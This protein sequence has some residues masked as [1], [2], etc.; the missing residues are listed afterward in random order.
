MKKIVFGTMMT[1]GAVSLQGAFD[2]K[3]PNVSRVD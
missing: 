3:Y 2:T 1:L